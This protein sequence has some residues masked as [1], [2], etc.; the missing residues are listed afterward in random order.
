[1]RYFFIVIFFIQFLLADT[2]SCEDQLF[3]LSAY[4]KDGSSLTVSNILKELS[5]K[6]DMSILFKDKESKKRINKTLDFVNIKNYTFEDFLDFLF[7]EA[8]LFYTYDKEKHFIT[9][10]YRKTKTFNIDYI[11]ISELTSQSSKSISSGSS[12]TTSDSTSDTS[13]GSSGASNAQTTITTKSKFTFWANLTNNLSKLFYDPKNVNMFVNQGASL[14]TVTADKK[15][16]QRVDDYLKRLMKRMHQ[17]VLIEVKLI[18]LTYDDSH[19]TGIDWNQL[20]LNLTGSISGTRTNGSK[21]FSHSY[22]IA[23]GF[24]TANFFKYL[25]T[26]GQVKVMSN[27]KILTMN[28][29]PAVVNVGEQLSY[30]YQTGSVTT[31][32]GTAAGTNTYSLGSTFVGI[33]L[34]VIPEITSNGEILMSVNPVVSA[35]SEKSASTNSATIREIPPDTKIKQ[36]TSIVKVKDGQKVLIGG[37]ISAVKGNETRKIPILGDLPILSLVFS[38]KDVKKSRTEMFILITP[39]IIKKSSM[40]TIDDID[41]DKFFSTKRLS[42]KDINVTRIK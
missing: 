26:L 41:N 20:N 7:D 37:L 28:N 1:M 23:Y 36:M 39:R 29:Q 2:N 34:Y 35:L 15:D 3:S 12:S 9:V 40:P 42:P 13:G 14:L 32:G 30:K 4:G 27:P 8:N 11:N 17:Q 25:N 10:R 5:Y 24:S 19:S 31:T 6:C 18:E 33:T 21:T 38:H 22:N 16:M